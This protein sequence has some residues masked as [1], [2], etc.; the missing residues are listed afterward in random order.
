MIADRIIVEE[1]SRKFIPEVPPRAGRIVIT[2]TGTIPDEVVA[3]L[4]KMAGILARPKC[5]YKTV[6]RDC[7]KRNRYKR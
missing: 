2:F 4:K 7:A 6:K 1:T 3:T 5:T